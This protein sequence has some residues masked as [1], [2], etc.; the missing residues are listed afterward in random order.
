MQ[1][2]I[3]KIAKAERR[4]FFVTYIKKANYSLGPCLRTGYDCHLTCDMKGFTYQTLFAADL[5]KA[6]LFWAFT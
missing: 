3:F 4:Y 2:I 1:I 5:T 6:S